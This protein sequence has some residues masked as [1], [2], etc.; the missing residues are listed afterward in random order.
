MRSLKVFPLVILA[1]AVVDLALSVALWWIDKQI[2]PAS[3]VAGS[4]S[5]AGLALLYCVEAHRD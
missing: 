5:Y 3:V 2:S 4:V 1:A